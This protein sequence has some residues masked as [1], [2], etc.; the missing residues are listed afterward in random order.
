MIR[1]GWDKEKWVWADGIIKVGGIGRVGVIACD[2]DERKVGDVVYEAVE[3][4]NGAWS[5]RVA[6]YGGKKKS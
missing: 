6:I 1:V 5:V 2:N 4:V 3:K